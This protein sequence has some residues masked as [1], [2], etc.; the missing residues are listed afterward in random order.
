MLSLFFFLVKHASF[1]LDDLL[2]PTGTEQLPMVA[3]RRNL[4]GHDVANRLSHAS[5]ITNSDDLDQHELDY[6]SGFFYFSFFQIIFITSLLFPSVS[7]PL[8]SYSG[9]TMLLILLSFLNAFIK[10]ICFRRVYFFATW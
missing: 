2:H 5:A 6:S 10:F 9:Q 4:G 1:V 8:F 7:L 3:P